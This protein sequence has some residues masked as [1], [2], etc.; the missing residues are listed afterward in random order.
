MVMAYRPEERL[1]RMR[2]LMKPIDRQIM[3]CDDQQ[4]IL[5]LACIMASTANL[6]F[7]QQL[8]RDNARKVIMTLLEKDN[9]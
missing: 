8:G 3:M 5:A 2:E 4:D 6:I 9:D 1:A 7:V